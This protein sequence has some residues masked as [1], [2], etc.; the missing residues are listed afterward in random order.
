MHERISMK[1]Q[2]LL[3]SWG[4][5]LQ[6]YQFA[7][8]YCQHKHVMDAGCGVGY[9]SQYLGRHGA[10]SVVGIDSS[11]EAIEEAASTFAHSNVRF[12]VGDLEASC[13]L[14]TRPGG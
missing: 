4:D 3:R 13:A 5:H 6:R 8:P 11:L 14:Q 12:V 1:D 9:G 2:S 10:S 7:A